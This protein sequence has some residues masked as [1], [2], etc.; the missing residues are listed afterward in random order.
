MYRKEKYIFEN[1]N[2][3]KVD[4]QVVHNYMQNDVVLQ[5]KLYNMW[6]DYYR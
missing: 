6:M 2:G 5:R 3:N 1:L 4:L